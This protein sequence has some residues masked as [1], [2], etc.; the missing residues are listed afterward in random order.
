M[1]GTMLRRMIVGGAKNF[2]R[3]G[4]VSFATVLIMTV[5]LL[6]IG[7]LIFLSAT[8]THTME[9]IKEKVDI[10]IYFVPT[11]SETEIFTVRDQLAGLEEVSA[12]V[13]TSREQALQEFTLRHAEDEL[14]LQALEE[15]GEN[16]LG[17]SLSVTAKD[18]SQY[19]RIAVFLVDQNSA[20]GTGFSAIEDINYFDNKTVIDRLTA[21]I[22]ASESAG[23]IVILLFALASSVIAFA[24]IRLAIYTARDE[25]AVMRLVGASNMYIRGPFIVEG[26]M[27]GLLAAAISLILFYPVTWYVGTA[28]S[29]WLGGF[30]L[31]AYYLENFGMVFLVLVGA[32]VLLSG[33]SSWFAVRKYLKV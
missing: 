28:M 7:F 18:P 33:V 2:V 31:F 19:E 14:T 25:I 17:A 6:I 16:P 20:G 5:T 22:R 11:A 26:I 13:Y 29:D 30:N 10:N 4:S 3:S 23:I 9:A 15:L 27:A 21:A 24:T 8:L 32:G 1:N 12:V